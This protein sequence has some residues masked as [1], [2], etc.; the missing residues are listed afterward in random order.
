MTFND[1]LSG[2]FAARAEGR[3]GVLLKLL[4]AQ[5]FKVGRVSPLRAGRPLTKD[6]AHGVTPPYVRTTVD[7]T[8]G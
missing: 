5:I 3:G 4:E 2:V 6:G 1:G 7:E 8:N